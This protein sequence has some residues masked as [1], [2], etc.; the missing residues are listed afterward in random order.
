[1]ITYTLHVILVGISKGSVITAGYSNA[2]ITT[3]TAIGLRRCTFTKVLHMPELTANL[4]STELLRKKGVFYR[5]DRQYLFIRYTDNKDVIIA[6]I[7]LYDGLP[8]LVTEP[9]VIALNS[10]VATKLEALMLV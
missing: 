8:Y 1:M 7:Y 6:D 10:K 9:N 4:L 3:Q 5:S 2:E